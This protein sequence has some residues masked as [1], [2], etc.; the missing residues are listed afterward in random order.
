[1]RISLPQKIIGEGDK[2]VNDL[3]RQPSHGECKIGMALQLPTDL[4]NN[5]IVG[6]HENSSKDYKG[7]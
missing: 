4:L 5:V 3:V 6:G 2:I 1:M 7:V